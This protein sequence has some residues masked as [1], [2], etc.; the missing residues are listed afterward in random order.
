[1]H[2]ALILGMSLGQSELTAFRR[3]AAAYEFSERDAFVL[4]DALKSSNRTVRIEAL[5]FWSRRYLDV[6]ED[7][8]YARK[9]GEDLRPDLFMDRVGRGFARALRSQNSQEKLHAVGAALYVLGGSIYDYYTEGPGSDERRVRGVITG[10]LGLWPKCQAEL[11]HYAKRNDPDLAF[12]AVMMHPEEHPIR[13]SPMVRNWVDSNYLR[14]VRAGLYFYEPKDF[15]EGFEIA[16]RFILNPDR[17]IAL[18]CTRNLR[19][20]KKDQAA[21]DRNYATLTSELQLA[22]DHL[23]PKRSDPAIAKKVQLENLKSPLASRR[24]NALMGYMDQRQYDP[25]TEDIRL[26]REMLSDPDPKVVIQ[27]IRYLI[28]MGVPDRDE[29]TLKILELDPTAYVNI[30]SRSQ[31]ELYRRYVT[32]VAD[33]LD[34]SIDASQH[35][36]ALKD[37]DLSPATWLRWA[38]SPVK[39]VRLRSFWAAPDS[40]MPLLIPEI[41]RA[42]QSDD[43]EVRSAGLTF[44]YGLKDTRLND[45]ILEL[46]S[47][48]KGEERGKALSVLASYGDERAKT[49]LIEMRRAPSRQERVV[50]REALDRLGVRFNLGGS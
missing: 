34:Q 44:R 49:P 37:A 39:K 19:W 29:L 43:P 11:L 41:V 36:F 32:K 16:R 20:T 6:F 40:A 46:A 3:H 42:L 50:A 13:R 22:F 45:A 35:L 28:Q 33:I 38:Q 26:C 23:N 30:E 4:A 18:D 14:F 24:L 31:P 7:L 5:T 25:R 47:R 2:C 17:D 9:V 1:M 8:V 10:A 12:A 21:F 48:S 27:A 15:R